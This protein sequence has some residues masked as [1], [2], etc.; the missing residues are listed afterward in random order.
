MKARLCGF[1]NNLAI[2]RPNI[3]RRFQSLYFLPEV[4]SLRGITD[5][6]SAAK[7]ENTETNDRE[8]T[9]ERIVSRSDTV[10]RP[11][12]VEIDTRKR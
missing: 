9:P 7:N 2:R 11:A 4:W 1:T 8:L 5:A 10:H 12:P 3:I 6:N